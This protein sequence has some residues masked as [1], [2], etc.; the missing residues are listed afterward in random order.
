MQTNSAMPSVERTLLHKGA[1]FDFERLAVTSPGGGI[2]YREC[3]RHPGAVIIL[4][5]LQTAMGPQV[6]LIR[7]WRAS[8]EEWLWEL[9]AGTL[10]AGEDPAACAA[11]ELRE[12]AGHSATTLTPLL[13]FRTSPGLSDELMH[14]YLATNLTHVGQRLEPDERLTVHPLPVERVMAMLAEGHVSDAKT[15]LTLLWADRL[16]LLDTRKAVLPNT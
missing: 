5:L 11:R 12:E 8:V 15:I 14:A 4:P 6:L 13:T 9:P 2:L 3:V 7:N 16:G 10:E 1:K